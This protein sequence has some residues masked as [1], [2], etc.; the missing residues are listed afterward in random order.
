MKKYIRFVKIEHTLFS[1][2]VVFAGTFLALSQVFRT[3]TLKESFWILLAVLT[4]RAVGF[5][6]NRII[7]RDLDAKNPRTKERELPSGTISL[8]AAWLFVALASTIFIFSAGMLSPLCLFLS[9]IPLLLFWLYPYLKRWT[10]W[11]HLGLGIAWGIAPIGG[12]LAVYPHFNP[13]SQLVPVLLLALFCIFWVA[14]FDILYATLDEDFD[15]KNSLFS[16]PALLGTKN[17]LRISEIFHLTAF[18]FL[19]TL[20][21][22]YLNH[23]ISFLFLALIGGFFILSHWKVQTQTLTPKVVDFAFFKTNAVVSFLVFGL[24]LF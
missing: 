21:K 16:I 23:T 15:R 24:V 12:Y 8:S 11:S 13:F 7:D 14:G 5:G 17:A 1:L 6:L 22:L 19:G 10:I 3:L 2:P 18:L 4:A 20:T 9:P